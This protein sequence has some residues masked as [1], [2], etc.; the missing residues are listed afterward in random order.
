MAIYAP[1]RNSRKNLAGMQDV[2]PHRGWHHVLGRTSSLAIR[3]RSVPPSTAKQRSSGC[4]WPSPM[5]EGS[6][7]GSTWCSYRPSEDDEASMVVR[8]LEWPASH[9]KEFSRRG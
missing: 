9:W 1:D 3:S 5:S 8:A 7:D 2:G 4:R 6:G